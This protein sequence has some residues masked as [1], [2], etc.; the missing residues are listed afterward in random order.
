MG[1]PHYF[2]AVFGPLEED[3]KTV[4]SGVYKPNPKHPPTATAGDVL[5]LYCTSNYPDYY[6][7]APG[8]GIVLESAP[9][10]V[11]YRWLPF[12]QPI[13]RQSINASLEPEAADRFGQ[14]HFGSNW[15]I[16]ISPESFSKIMSERTVAWGK[17]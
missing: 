12:A 7:E 3:K 10:Q 17:L 5:L 15:L 16:E 14:L 4:E 11:D 13:L 1:K 8:L 6:M 9:D 2:I